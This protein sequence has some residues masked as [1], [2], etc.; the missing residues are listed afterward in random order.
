MKRWFLLAALIPV[1]AGLARLRFDTD[2]LNLL[3]GDLPAVAGLKLYQKH[4]ANNRELIVTVSG[5]FA[6]KAT[7]L[8]AEGLRKSTGLVRSAVWRAPWEDG[9]ENVGQ[10]LAWLWLSQPPEKV[11]Q[12][13]GR[14]ANAPAT[15]AAARERLA[16]SLDFARLGYDPFGISELGAG[17]NQQRNW[18]GSEDGTFRLIFVQPA[19]IPENLDALTDWVRNVRAEV[20]AVT[21][22]VPAD[23]GFTGTPAFTVETAAGMKSDMRQSVTATIILVAALFYWAHRR[24]WPLLWMLAM[25]V[26]SLIVTMALGGLIFGSLNV[27]SFGFAAILLGLGVDYA[28]VSYQELLGAPGASAAEVRA[29]AAP[30]I[31]WSAGTTALAF[32]LLSFAGLPGLG[33][34]GT[35]VAIGV[36]I[37]AAAMLH[38]FLP[39]MTLRPPVVKTHGVPKR[40][41]RET[42]WLLTVLLLIVCGGTLLVAR[43][44]IDRSA[45]PLGSINSEASKAAK[46]IDDR[47]N[48]GAETLWLLIE[49]RDEAEVRERMEQL[50]ATGADLPIEIWPIPARQKENLARLRGIDFGKLRI[51]AEEAGF[52]EDALT[53]A[54]DALEAW[55]RNDGRIWL[56]ES[57]LVNRVAAQTDRGPVAL[58]L[59]RH[60]TN[61]PLPQISVPGV[62]V[63]GWSRL[64]GLLMERLERRLT[65]LTVAMAAALV[66]CLRLALGC[67]KKVGLSFAALG[68]GF[69][70]LIAVMSVFGLKWNLLSLTAIPLL[71]GAAVDYT[72]HVQLALN[73]HAD[74]AAE[75]RRTI[76]RALF[77]VTAAAVAGFGSLA[78]AS[79]AGIASFE[80]VC[81]VGM[82]CIFLTSLYLL[83]AWH[84]TFARKTN[85]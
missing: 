55:K 52:T 46:L 1:I 31:W 28:L 53:L 15:L 17:M 2:V 33:Q 56:E 69:I 65:I 25:L 22:E 4:F 36:M 40:P 67:W 32:A 27:V 35:L 76:G 77:L 24:F 64:A 66:V 20:A 54:R 9:S 10:F 13:V 29:H 45:D 68:F 59:L 12:L 70:L 48:R 11:D 49:G 50:K 73:R 21:K 83:P 71:L 62:T 16:T 60:R 58:G 47:M 85:G 42:G 38:G 75:M 19:A 8:I 18:F 51:A 5:E 41:S 44:G 80:I 78:L 79:N 84:Y 14:F 43:P 34:L 30:G 7:P 57:W 72:I 26:S 39:L 3:P 74:D 63:A 81:A 37:A 82:I 6:E 61:E 23:V